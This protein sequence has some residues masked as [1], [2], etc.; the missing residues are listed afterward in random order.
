MK[1]S[2][3]R[4]VLVKAVSQAQSVVERRNTIP[5]LSNVLLSAGRDRLAFA[6]TDLDMEMVDEAEAT[7]FLKLLSGRNHR[8]FTGVAVWRDGKLSSR[9]NETRV[10]FKPLSDHEIASYVATGDW[11][12]KAGGYAIQGAAADIIRRAMIRVEDALAE[13]KLSAQMLLQVHDE[14]IFEVPD[15]EVAATLPVVQKVMQ[16]APFPAV[17]LSLPLQVDARAANNWD[18]AH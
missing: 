7:R 4:A 17:I 16:D 1:F 15:N 10:T 8:V 5:I 6:A 9:V 3:E 13:K 11:R 2:I 12:G 18:E 14:L